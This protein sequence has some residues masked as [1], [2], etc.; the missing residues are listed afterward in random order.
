MGERGTFFAFAHL[1]TGPVAE[2]E[3]AH[4]GVP[5]DYSWDDVDEV[6]VDPGLVVHSA[7]LLRLHIYKGEI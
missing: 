1:L 2:F 3:D 6:L 4:E 7:S 5:E